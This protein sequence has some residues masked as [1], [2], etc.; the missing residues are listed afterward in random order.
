MVTR[1]RRGVR[2]SGMRR[3]STGFS[4]VESL[5]AILVLGIGF[6]GA[7]ATLL[8]ALRV[9]RFAQRYTEGVR[10]AQQ[11]IARFEGTACPLLRDS[12]WQVVGAAGG[13]HRWAM[14]V[15]DSIVSL[16]GSLAIGM[17]ATVPRLVVALHRRCVE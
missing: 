3:S 10:L 1:R 12:A 13:D 7:T 14:Q 6:S 17:E 15:R 2:S 8:T 5:V 4:L 16:T 9:E 11:E